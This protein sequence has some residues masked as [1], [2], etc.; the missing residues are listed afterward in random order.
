MV[1]LP[2]DHLT[3]VHWGCAFTKQTPKVTR[4]SFVFSE[5]ALRLCSPTT[6][7]HLLC[8]HNTLISNAE[9]FL[10]QAETNKTNKKPPEWIQQGVRWALHLGQG[11]LMAGTLWG[12]ADPLQQQEAASISSSCLRNCSWD[13]GL[14]APT[15]TKWKNS[16]RLQWHTAV[17]SNYIT[18]LPI[19]KLRG[20]SFPSGE[21]C[22]NTS[23]LLYSL[24]F[25]WWA[26][27]YGCEN[28]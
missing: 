3:Q 17:S 7:F 4:S 13:I 22:Y 2:Q 28:K 12:A 1:A 21:K 6:P 19:T 23:V 10:H 27:S 14:T 25:Q 8:G 15:Q 26:V 20:I 5:W 9:S 24:T 16:H 18:T 11:K